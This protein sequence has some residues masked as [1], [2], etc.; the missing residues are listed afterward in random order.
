[1]NINIKILLS[2]ALYLNVMTEE[3]LFP[4]FKVVD[5]LLEFITI[6]KREKPH[7]HLKN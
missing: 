6:I 7:N 2:V 4:G 3:G 5:I 1:M